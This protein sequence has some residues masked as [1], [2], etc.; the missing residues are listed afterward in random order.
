MPRKLLDISRLKSLGWEP[1]IGLCEGLQ[2]AYDWF[3]D[4]QD[5]FRG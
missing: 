1:R 5:D 4:R 3:I 2:S